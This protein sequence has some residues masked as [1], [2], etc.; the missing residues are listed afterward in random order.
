MRSS[1]WPMLALLGSVACSVAATS[2]AD[3][4][5]APVEPPVSVSPEVPPRV[6]AAVAGLREAC[7]AW[8]PV[9]A[10]PDDATPVPKPVAPS[11]PRPE[12]TLCDMADNPEWALLQPMIFGGVA[13]AILLFVGLVVFSLLRGLLISAWHWRLPLGAKP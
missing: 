13:G 6:T 5:A 11:P 12:R 3:P 4:I 7:A 9:I 10:I 8:R 1:R 2:H